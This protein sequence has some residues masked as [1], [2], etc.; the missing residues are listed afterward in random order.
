MEQELIEMLSRRTPREWASELPYTDE[1]YLARSIRVVESFLPEWEERYPNDQIPSRAV[2]SARALLKE[3]TSGLESQAELLAKECSK[4][5]KR[6]LG[7]T[8]RIAESA[9]EIAKAAATTDSQRRIELIGE[10]LSYAEEHVL[11]MHA[12]KG[13]YGKEPEVRHGFLMLIG[14]PIENA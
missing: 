4:A 1:E 5:R 8:Y 2:D 6:S 11:Y 13:N 14:E 10:S 3:R 7:Y 12:V 9:R